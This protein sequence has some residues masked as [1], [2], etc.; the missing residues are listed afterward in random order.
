MV[1][2]MVKEVRAK[3]NISVRR[4]AEISGISKTYINEVEN[5]QKNPTIEVLC[6][7]AKALEVPVSD[8]FQCIEEEG[9]DY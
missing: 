2:I 3:K 4:L 9:S 1:K 6:T 8:L 5:G 7:L